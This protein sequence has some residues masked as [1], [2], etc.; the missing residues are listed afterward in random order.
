MFGIDIFEIAVEFRALAAVGLLLLVGNWT[1][2][3]I[4]G[5][6]EDPTLSASKFG[7]AGG[8]SALVTGVH[9][10]A[11]VVGLAVYLLWP[12]FVESPEL[13]FIPVG[14]VAIHYYFEDMER[15]STGLFRGEGDD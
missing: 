13:L 14:L 9:A 12:T 6:G 11:L 10:V 4:V 8:F 1:W 3:R 15:S 5:E 7:L 2:E